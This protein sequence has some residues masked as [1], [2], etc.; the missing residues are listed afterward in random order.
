MLTWWKNK[1]LVLQCA[2]VV[3]SLLGSLDLRLLVLCAHSWPAGQTSPVAVRGPEL[4]SYFLEHLFL[5]WHNNQGSWAFGKQPSVLQQCGIFYEVPKNVSE[6][7]LP[8]AEVRPYKH[9]GK[10]SLHLLP[11]FRFLSPPAWVCHW[12]SL[13]LYILYLF[14]GTECF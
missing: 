6:P 2:H 8:W 5:S 13:I 14:G 1:T 4:T 9:G 11:R 12:I 7:V 10:M 3:F